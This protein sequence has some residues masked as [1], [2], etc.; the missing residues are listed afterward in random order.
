MELKVSQSGSLKIIHIK[1]KFDIECIE[2]FENTF[3]KQLASG[4]PTQLAID[5][6]QLDYIDSSGIGSLIKSLNT[7]KTQKGVLILYGL[8]PMILN[9]FKLAKL[10]M[11]F[12][13]MT[14]SEF[15][16]KYNNED[17]S[18]IDELLDKI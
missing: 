2:E 14:N 8:K 13:I 16:N 5:M 11:F 15:T 3:Q 17:D 6:N 7:I 4:K 10:D 12:Q 9:V 1:G 18:D